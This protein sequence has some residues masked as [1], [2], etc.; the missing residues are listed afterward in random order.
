MDEKGT[1]NF[2]LQLEHF[3]ATLSTKK[4]IFIIIILGLI[5]FSNTLFNKFVWDDKVYIIFYPQIHSINI[6]FLFGKNLFNVGNQYRPLPALYFAILYSIFST[7]PF[8]YHFLQITLHLTNTAL[9]F[10]LFKHFFDRHLSLFL[11]LIFLVH[12]TQVE[13]VAYIA[14]S[15]NPLF[16]LFGISAF[17]LSLKDSISWRRLAAIFFLL[18]SSALTKET[19]VLFIFV[20]LLYRIII[21]K[22]KI[23]D[24]SIAGAAVL[25]IYYFLR[26]RV[27][28]IHFSQSVLSPIAGFSLM[29]RITHIPAIIFFYLRTFFF[30]SNL[31]VEQYWVINS[32]GLK[33]FYIP[34][35]ID[36]LFLFLLVFLGGYVFKTS[37]KTFPSFIFFA[38]WLLIGFS[39]YMQIIPV[40]YTVAERWFYFPLVGLLGV[41]G[42]GLHS[43]MTISGKYRALGNTLGVILIILLSIRTAVRNANWS[44]AMT[45][46]THDIKISESYDIENNLGAEYLYVKNYDEALKHFKNSETLLSF[47][48]NIVNIGYTYELMG[49]QSKAKEYFLK[50]LNAPS[51]QESWPL[52]QQVY[53]EIAKISAFRE[54]PTPDTTIFIKEAL[55]KYPKSD[56][57]WATLA[58]NEYELHNNVE[59]LTAAGEARTLFPSLQTKYLYMQIL[60]NQPIDLNRL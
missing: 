25:L 2:L 11:S 18:L 49:N 17:H 48:N 10:L 52:Y 32:L 23:F 56:I 38:L 9:L 29:G 26:V 8:F 36:S 50:S 35:L 31:A 16:F 58:Y 46:F 13:S 42:I 19:G 55:Q 5:I 15:G 7:H 1:N 22:G 24:L 43:I 33:S 4:A 21:K 60:N 47:V 59:A 34:L 6:P 27:I 14:S 3:F 44:D 51:Y 53:E 12:P 40:D 37:R 30:P 57:L 20:I 45:L 28:G 39:I 41:L 54:D